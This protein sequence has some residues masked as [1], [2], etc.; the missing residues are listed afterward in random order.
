M[1]VSFEKW[2]VVEFLSDEKLIRLL[3]LIFSETVRVYVFAAM[4]ITFRFHFPR[5]DWK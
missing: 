3:D 1:N 4:L 2:I 5:I